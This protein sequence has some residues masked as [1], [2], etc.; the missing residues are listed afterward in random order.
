MDL[1]NIDVDSKWG[2]G[3]A[4]FESVKVSLHLERTCSMGI[5]LTVFDELKQRK[6]CCYLS[7]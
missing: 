4:V 3:V 2:K 1:L 6:R 5:G 7:K